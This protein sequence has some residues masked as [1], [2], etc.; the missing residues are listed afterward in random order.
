M[1]FGRRAAGVGP[2]RRSHPAGRRRISVASNSGANSSDWL[3]RLCVVGVDESGSVGDETLASRRDGDEGLVTGA[4]LISFWV[5]LHSFLP[6][7]ASFVIITKVVQ[8]FRRQKPGLCI[9]RVNSNYMDEVGK[10]LQVPSFRPA[11]NPTLKQSLNIRRVPFQNFTGGFICRLEL[12]WVGRQ[13]A[14]YRLW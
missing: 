9:P 6:K 12:G 2:R 13:K 11:N 14:T 7:F 3:R 8:D 10:G 5:E 4:R 1:R